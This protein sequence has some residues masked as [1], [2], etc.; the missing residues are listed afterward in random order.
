MSPGERLL[1]Q[2][3]A[4]KLRS[5]HSLSRGFTLIELMI[6][7]A[8]V[9]VLAAIAYPSYMDYVRKGKR[10]MAQAALMEIVSKEQTYLLDRRV[11]TNDVTLLNYSLPAEIANDYDITFPGFNAAAIPPAF[12][13][14]ATPKGQQVKEKCGWLQITNVGVKTSEGSTCWE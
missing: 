6:T 13:V 9:A 14:R 8:I 4:M 5:F 1:R 3:G 2:S 10:A 12:S 7:V 11:Y